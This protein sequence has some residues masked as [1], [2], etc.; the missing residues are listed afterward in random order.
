MRTDI[1]PLILVFILLTLVFGLYGCERID[2]ESIN[3]ITQ[4]DP[5]FKNTLAAKEKL[6][7]EIN[8]L[9]T[10]LRELKADTYSKIR[11]LEDDFNKRK[12]EISGKIAALKNELEPE[13][14]R[15]KEELEKLK[16]VL[17]GKKE[18]LKNLENTRRNLTNLINQQKA[19]SVTR[20]EM[21]KWQDN[22]AGLEKE[23]AP[24]KGEVREFEEKIRLLKLKLISLRQ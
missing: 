3:K 18:V 16:G 1:R 6:D 5:A 4:D 14:V 11:V 17:S 2:S 12:N 15:I 8:R 22:L 19:V 21:A 9:L 20:E 23:I 24:L 13:R 10:E 7:Q